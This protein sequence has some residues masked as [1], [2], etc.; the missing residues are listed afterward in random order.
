VAPVTRRTAGR[1]D[2][3]T[4]ALAAVA[5]VAA[6][7]IP[8]KPPS[9][10]EPAHAIADHLAAN[11]ASIL[12]G[13][14][15]IALASAGFLWFLGVL[16]GHESAAGEERLSGAA[17][18]GG[19]VGTAL[20]AAAAAVQAGLVLNVRELSD[21]LVRLGFDA[22]NALVTMAGAPLAVAAGA[23]ALSAARTGSLPS[24][25]VRTGALTAVLQL[26]TLPGLVLEGGFFAAG[27]P[28]AL[29]AFLAIAGWFGAV[30][31]LLAR[32]A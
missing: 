18:L 10:D 19:A 20:V 24:W 15:L 16:R 11:R 30:S 3:A 5:F 13:A 27:G 28:M 6:F 26:L 31:V 8:G 17:A 29:A 9:P 32:R 4:G 21:E 12:A 22:Y 23:A 25:T 14:V 7:A 2:A 1:L